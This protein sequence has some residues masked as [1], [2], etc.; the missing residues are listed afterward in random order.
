MLCDVCKRPWR[1]FLLPI[2]FPTILFPA[3]PVLVLLSYAPFFL[4]LSSPL[5]FANFHTTNLERAR[6]AILG[7]ADAESAK[8][9]HLT[10]GWELAF[11]IRLSRI[12]SA[13][14]SPIVGS[15]QVAFCSWWK[16]QGDPPLVLQP[17]INYHDSF[18]A[19]IYTFI[20][21]LVTLQ[22]IQY[23]IALIVSLI[24]LYLSAITYL[25][26]FKLMLLKI[27]SISLLLS[28]LFFSEYFSLFCCNN[29]YFKFH[30]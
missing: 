11:L 7:E 1:S 18:K 19:V 4:S 17:E 15:N 3:L 8:T 20:N 9:N 10:F 16:V 29:I 24:V 13:M 22:Y 5:S 2:L 28:K 14:G 6:G 23:K 30:N 25:S 26:H 21:Q 27:D 12:N